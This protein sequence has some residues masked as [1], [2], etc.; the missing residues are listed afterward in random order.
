MSYTNTLNSRL[1]YRFFDLTKPENFLEFAKGSK[2]RI[3]LPGSDKEIEYDSMPR[4]GITL[5]KLGA[6]QSIMLGS[7]DFAVSKLKNR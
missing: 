4:T 3:L 1:S 5:S 2:K 7:Y 6:S